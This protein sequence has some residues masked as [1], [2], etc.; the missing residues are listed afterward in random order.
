M[1]VFPSKTGGYLDTTNLYRWWNKA[2]DAAGVEWAG[3]H[4]LRH[5]CATR[6]FRTG[7]NAKQVQL[8]LGHHSPAFTLSVYVHVLDEELPTPTFTAPAVVESI[9]NQALAVAQEA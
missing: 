4:T 3:F 7:W 9:D 5:T 6:L 2:A 8:M 1:L